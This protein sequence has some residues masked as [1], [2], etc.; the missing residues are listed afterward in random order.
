M[1]QSSYD[2]DDPTLIDSVRGSQFPMIL[3][4]FLIWLALAALA[5]FFMYCCS[6]VSNGR[7]RTSRN[8]ESAAEATTQSS[9]GSR[10]NGTQEGLRASGHRF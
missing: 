7:R 2:D 10:P 8:D 1:H 5:V 4:V 6:R 9:A 3:T